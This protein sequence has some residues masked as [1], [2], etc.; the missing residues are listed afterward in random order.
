MNNMKKYIYPIV[1]TLSI[2]IFAGCS[3]FTNKGAAA[4][5]EE[6]GR[7]KIVNVD[8]RIASNSIAKIDQI[9]VL[10]YGTDYALSKV[11]DPAREVVVARDMNQRVMSISGNPSIEKIKEMQSTIDK[12]TSLLS[13]EREQ[14]KKLLDL[15]DTQINELQL[16]TRS[17]MESKEL[18]IKKYMNIAQSA[19]AT[20]DA[21]KAQMDKMDQWLGLG[22]IFYGIKKFIFSSMWILGIGS[23]LFLVLRIASMSNPIAASAFSIFNIIGSWVVNGIGVIFPKALEFAGNTAT[24]VFNAYRG[25]MAKIID[26][27]QTI[28]ERQRALGDPN[29]KFTLDEVMDELAKIMSDDDKKRVAEIKREIGYH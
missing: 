9:S 26:G 27:I 22:A 11:D 18:E 13:T 21:F 4:K 23:V 8:S 17:L 25:T 3:I 5:A 14:G 1:L 20:A 29:K 15:R 16:E 12:L 24:S 6:K 19:A 7:A 2:I 28:K 10:A